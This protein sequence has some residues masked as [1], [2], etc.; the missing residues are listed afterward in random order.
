MWSFKPLKNWKCNYPNIEGLTFQSF[1][2]FKDH[3][4]DY[5]QSLE[6]LKYW[7]TFVILW[8]LEGL[9]AF[10]WRVEGSCAI[11]QP[12]EGLKMQ[13]FKVEGLA[14][15]SFKALNDYTRNPSKVL[16]IAFNP[17]KD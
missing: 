7:N 11:L 1:G 3:M 5:L 4:W 15:Q 6:G 17:L 9:C 8:R 2:G 16:M 10:I 12:L 14:F 13:S